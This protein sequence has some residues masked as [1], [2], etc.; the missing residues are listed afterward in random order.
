LRIPFHGAAMTGAF[1]G[2]IPDLA[3]LAA[4]AGQE[5]SGILNFTARLENRNGAQA[6]N[7]T[8]GGKSVNLAN[9][10]VGLGDVAAEL[11]LTDAFGTPAIAAEA[12]AGGIIAG[13]QKIRE[14]TA[15]AEG[16][17]TALGYRFEVT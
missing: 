16:D 3:S 6:I 7:A 1:N 17:L 14:V 10:S 8:L 12:R 4:L 13:G 5:M 9:G 2:N 11:A 15:S